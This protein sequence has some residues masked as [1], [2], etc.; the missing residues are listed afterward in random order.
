MYYFFL[1]VYGG[2]LI[3]ISHS[4][5]IYIFIG[6]APNGSGYPLLV[7]ARA[8]L[9][10]IRFYPSRSPTPGHSLMIETGIF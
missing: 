10:A 2:G 1:N 7:L 3:P 5:C 4:C 6:R 9:R 8:S